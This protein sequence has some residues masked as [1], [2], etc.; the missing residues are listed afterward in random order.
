MN[1]MEM[2][3]NSGGENALAQ[4]GGSV[5]L[6]QR[7]TQAALEQLLPALGGGLRRNM[8]QEG[9]LDGLLAALTSGNHARYVDNPSLMGDADTVSDGNAILGHLLGSKD[10]SR[11][12]A[13]HASEQTGIGSD[14]LKQMLPLAAT[15]LMGA[16]SKQSSSSG[17]LGNSAAPAQPEGLL[18][19]LTPMLDSDGDGSVADDVAGMIGRFL[20]NR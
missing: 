4:L 6:D 10:V 17:F 15:M 3:M 12:V 20:S 2:L 19:M 14:V 1:L 13:A 16:L 8:A 9:G 18:G 5:G 11:Q 7:Q